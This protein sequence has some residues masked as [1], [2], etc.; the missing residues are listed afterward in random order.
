[1]SIFPCL[2]ST[3]FLLLCPTVVVERPSFQATKASPTLHH[4]C[5]FSA[6]SQFIC[7]RVTSKLPQSTTQSSK[8]N[9]GQPLRLT[10]RPSVVRAT[11][12]GDPVES[13]ENDALKARPI[14]S[15]AFTTSSAPLLYLVRSPPPTSAHL[16]IYS[17]PCN[18]SIS[19]VLVEIS[20]PGRDPP[21]RRSG[22]FGDEASSII[23]SLS[24]LYN[25]MV[26]TFLA[27]SL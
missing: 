12:I 18:A 27:D 25:Y 24:Y 13:L 19:F 2:L 9:L 17:W 5:A 26:S 14:S 7:T 16:T 1:M 23:A 4:A 15:D 22:R 11:S 10:G 21:H 3:I 8:A 20:F 6:P